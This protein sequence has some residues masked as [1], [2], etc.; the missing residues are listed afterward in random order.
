MDSNSVEWKDFELSVELHKSYLDFI[1]KLNLFHYAITGAILSFHFSK[2]SP[3]DSVFALILPIVLSILLGSFFLYCSKLAMNLRYNIK[4]R[5]EKLGLHVFPEGI[6][7][8]ILCVIFGIT[9]LGVGFTLI[10]YLIC[11]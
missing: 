4:F 2:E 1:I 6:V 7:L 5:A 9:M 10:G 8:V 11:K 3:E